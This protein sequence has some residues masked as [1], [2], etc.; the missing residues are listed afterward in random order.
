MIKVHSQPPVLLY[1]KENTQDRQTVRLILPGSRPDIIE[2]L[3]EVDQVHL[4]RELEA[5][6][7]VFRS[8]TADIP[9]VEVDLTELVVVCEVGSG[10]AR[11]V[12]GPEQR[13]MLLM[14]Q[15]SSR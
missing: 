9:P 7:R 13:V 10:H 3:L 15:S 4:H 8:C 11:S 2:L 5:V 1:L 6:D 12:V 14:I